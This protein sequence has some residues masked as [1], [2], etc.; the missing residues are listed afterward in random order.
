MHEVNTQ[1]ASAEIQDYIYLHDNV[2][3]TTVGIDI[4][5][6]TFHLM[7]AKVHL[8]RETQ[9]H[10]SRFEIVHRRIL[11][12]SEI[13]LTPYRNRRIDTN[14]VRLFVEESYQ[15]AGLHPSQIDS[16]AVIL[17][18]EALRQYNARSLADAVAAESGD[19]VC[20]SAGHHLEATLAAFGSGAVKYSQEHAIRLFH[21]DIGGGTT[22]LALI[23][24]G[25]VIATAAVMVGGRQISLG[26]QREIFS[27]SAGSSAIARHAGFRI[28]LGETLTEVNEHR[29]VGA[30]VSVI[31]DLAAANHHNT[32]E[33]EIR[34]T[35]VLPRNFRPDAVSF[36]GGVSEYIYRR[37]TVAYGDLGPHI[38][39]EIQRAIENG[40]ITLPVVDPGEGIRAT[41]AGASQ[42][43]VQLSGSTV[44]VSE[45]SMLPVRNVPVVHAELGDRRSG[46]DYDATGVADSIGRAIADYGLRVSDRLAL[47]FTW[48]GEPSF[49]RLSAF[50][51]GLSHAL[52]SSGQELL[53]VLIDQDI[54]ATIG[55]LLRSEYKIDRPLVCLDGL[56][57][58]PLDFVDIGT[59]IEPSGALP[60]V[61]KS[62]L[63]STER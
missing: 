27:S 26:A 14:L 44:F 43:S 20:V 6:S 4:G 41:V 31:V 46:E 58:S 60:V 34:L 15:K 8:K 59:I 63:F 48:S 11:W 53:I 9:D 18:G 47:S 39:S 24:N 30:Q 57:F 12:R 42:C 10:S 29:F 3:L 16:G 7:F 56:T 35:R 50:A 37:E 33:R 17:T 5:S 28:H 61:I 32:L 36:S 23:D 13:A 54:G 25:I 49:Q 52:S 45:P 38:G 55:R 19:F 51:E 1:G 2:E 21:I 22:K 40:V 62:L